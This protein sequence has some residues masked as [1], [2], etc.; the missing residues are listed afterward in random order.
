M[1][2]K[3]IVKYLVSLLLAVLL[4]YLV[5]RNVDLNDFIGRLSSVNYWWVL[6]SV[7][8]AIVSHL[9]RSYRWNLLLAPFGYK[10]KTQRTFL[11]VMSGYLANLALPRLGEVTRC[12]ILKK[13]DGVS[14]STA[15]GT[16]VVERLFDFIVL[17]LIIAVDF[18]VEFDMIYDYF[19]SSIGWERIEENKW[20]YLT[21]IMFLAILGIAGL[22]GLRL[23]LQKDFEN[24]SLKKAH[25]KLRDLVDGFL[26]IRKLEN[27]YGFLFSTVIIWITYFFMSY[28]IFF[29]IDETSVL[30]MGAGLS[31]LAA[32]GVAMAAPVQGGMGAYHALVS[33][34]LIIYGIASDTSL[35]FATLLHTSQVVFILIFGGISILLSTIISS[36]NK[37]E[38]VQKS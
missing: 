14:M 38:T 13:N 37:T 33:G 32:A 5:F 4:V 29:A 6:A 23:L 2:F 28:V 9:V 26:S 18:M 19:T 31:I 30:G 15:I 10:L 17:L 1:G 11:A 12:G 35:F 20:V 25:E 24:P 27:V 22:Y 21:I 36:K 7:L 16:V 34:V 3:D 8:L